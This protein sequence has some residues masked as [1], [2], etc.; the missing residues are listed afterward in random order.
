MN[1][2]KSDNIPQLSA[3]QKKF[4]RGL[5]H[6][7]PP[8]VL[9]GKEGLSPAIVAAVDTELAHHELIKVKIGSNSSVDKNEAAEVLA[10]KTASALAQVIGKTL[11]LYRPNP[12]K[13]KEKRLSLPAG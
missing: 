11:L 5:G 1:Q 7:L 3:K 2:N 8:L 9:V 4:L 10:Q 12:E 6:S 13:P